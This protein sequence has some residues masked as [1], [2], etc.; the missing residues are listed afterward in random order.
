VDPY[1]RILRRRLREATKGLPRADGT[2]YRDG[3]AIG[4][5]G[6]YRYAKRAGYGAFTLT[7]PGQIAD[8]AEGEYLMV[9]Y[10]DDPPNAQPGDELQLAD[11]RYRVLSIREGLGCA[12]WRLEEMVT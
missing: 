3:E 9:L 4:E 11:A 8:Q 2:L 6:G 7:L 12:T 10:P 5:A 1:G